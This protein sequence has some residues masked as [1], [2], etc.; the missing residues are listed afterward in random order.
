[1]TRIPAQ[2]SVALPLSYGDN[3]SQTTR[4]RS[5][6]VLY[7]SLLPQLHQR[8]ENNQESQ[9]NRNLSIPNLPT[10]NMSRV[11]SLPIHR[12][13]RSS[14][15]LICPMPHL[16][17]R[18]RRIRLHPALR[19]IHPPR[20]RDPLIHRRRDMQH[21]RCR[22][23]RHKEYHLTMGTLA[24][25]Q[26]RRD[27]PRMGFILAIMAILPIMPGSQSSQNEMVSIL[28]SVSSPW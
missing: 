19:T 12:M 11:H 8:Q 24:M 2:I 15:Q 23:T 10:A 6:S 14:D 16:S 1:M 25:R 26:E 28:L 22:A 18:D 9:R 3:G 27:T 4:I 17:S 13:P 21:I 7:R 20:G 5:R